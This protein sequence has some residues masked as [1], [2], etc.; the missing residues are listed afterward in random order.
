MASFAQPALYHDESNMS[1]RI[2][3]T[4][5][6]AFFHNIATDLEQCNYA[7]IRDLIHEL[8]AK[9]RSLL[10][11]R[12]DLH[13]HVNDHDV[14]VCASVNDIYQVLIRSGLLLAS[15]LESPARS[16]STLELIDCLK[17]F[18]SQSCNDSDHCPIIPYGIKTEK[19][20]VVASIAY[21]HHKAD[22]CQL[23]VSNYKLQQMAPLVHLVGHEYERE[24]FLKIH[25]DY[26]S[27]TIA[28]LQHML[29]LTW[30]WI[31]NLQTLVSGSSS[32]SAY[33]SF[34]QNIEIVKGI[35]FVDGL[36]FTKS[37]T[38]VP[39]VLAFDIASIHHIRS[40]ARYCVIASAL[41]LHSC[42]I[43]R[44]G[45]SVLD[46]TMLSDDILGA[47]RVLSSALKE[48]HYEQTHLEDV[49]IEAV[50]N[51]TKGMMMFSYET[52]FVHHMTFF[53]HRLQLF[54][55]KLEII[56]LAE[57]VLSEEEV[58]ALRNH[59]L[60]VLH[61][62]DPVL[63]LLDNRVQVFFRFAC[64]YRSNTAATTTS[65]AIALPDMRTGI[66][67]DK[68][69]RPDVISKPGGSIRST[70][71]DFLLATRKEASRLGFA[72][73]GSELINAAMEA[74]GIVSLLCTNY[75]QD[76]LDRLMC[77]ARRRDAPK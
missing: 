6:L 23:D 66:H 12:K 16:S 33:P 8:H 70:N 48:I 15:Y 29:P 24:H 54:D 3:Q 27:S 18:S 76:I 53:S 7:S 51:L 71:E 4:M 40:E 74:R 68:M 58:I 34:D 77:A 45:T 49:V 39:E 75:G 2:A 41:A 64:R 17:E 52:L 72:F 38:S 26:H 65:A 56:A 30:N 13:S 1:V 11:S 32:V 36:L 69:I 46:S 57:R 60:A 22:L 73:V 43:S 21:I 42:N 35:G 28:E 19:L 67:A 63:K 50:C 61:G 20:L 47:R 31:Q 25:G 44:V 62:N 59:T 55:I 5:R 14:S 10:P 9:M 37:Q